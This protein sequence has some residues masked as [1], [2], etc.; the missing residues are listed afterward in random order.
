MLD[1]LS[2]RAA[3]SSWA[4]GS[5]TIR[6]VLVAVTLV[7]ASVVGAAPGPAHADTPGDFCTTSSFAT[8]SASPS[9]VPYG[10]DVSVSWN[11]TLR[12]CVGP[13][14]WIEGPHFSGNI[15]T[16][17]PRTVTADGEHNTMTWTLYLY[18]L[19]A[20]SQWPTPMASTTIVIRG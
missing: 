16:V 11:L 20:Q 1:M 3:R 17:G 19:Y 10:A 14:F 8:M 13:V 4:R 5:R 12:D 15:P 9:S 2:R 6:A 7:A 18:D